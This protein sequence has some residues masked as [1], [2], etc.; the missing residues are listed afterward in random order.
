MREAWRQ[1][2][3]GSVAPVAQCI[4]KELADKLNIRISLNFDSLFASDLVGQGSGVP[5][6]GRGWGWTLRRAA[7]LAG[8]MEDPG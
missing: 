1:F 5:V 4:E 7:G 8:L 6:D 3:H 2:F